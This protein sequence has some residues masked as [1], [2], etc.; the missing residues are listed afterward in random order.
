[1]RTYSNFLLFEDVLSNLPE[2]S[3]FIQ[4]AAARLVAPT[5]KIIE[6]DCGTLL[7][8]VIDVTFETEGL[9]ELATDLP[10]TRARL[11]QILSEGRYKVATRSLH[12]CISIGGVCR[13]CYKGQYLDETAPEV[14]TQKNLSAALCYQ[15]DIIV[16]NAYSMSYTMSQ[17]TDDFDKVLVIKNGAVQTSG[18]SVSGDQIIF[19][20]IPTY[21][22]IYVV[23]F[24]RETSEPLQGYMARSYS[25]DLLG[26][27]PL[28]TQVTLVRES[29]YPTII[30]D[31]MIAIMQTELSPY[32]TIPSTYLEYIDR[33]HDKLEKALFIVYIYAI[34]SNVQV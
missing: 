31:N 4:S 34:F 11:I 18:Y 33:I 23:R 28:P 26:M 24:Y 16:G 25:G 9:I 29:L 8:T 19:T 10:L 2:G 3:T 14:N 30:P 20:S 5:V 21:S 27:K 22:D 32:K 15:T 6:E 12:S 13:K 1:M 7:G 17:S